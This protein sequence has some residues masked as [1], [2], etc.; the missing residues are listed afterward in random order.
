MRVA[1]RTGRSLREPKRNPYYK[2]IITA[3]DLMNFFNSQPYTVPAPRV[4]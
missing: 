1:E 3:G 2:R 4:V